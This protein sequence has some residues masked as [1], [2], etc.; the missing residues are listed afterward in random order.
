[1]YKDI[2]S[3]TAQSITVKELEVFFTD[4]DKVVPYAEPDA[5]HQLPANDQQA[6]IDPEP[7]IPNPIIEQE[8]L[9]PRRAAA[10]AG[11]MKRQQADA[12]EEELREWGLF[13]NP[14]ELTESEPIST[15]QALEDPEWKDSIDREMSALIDI[16]AWKEPSEIPSQNIIDSMFVFKLK[17]NGIKKSRLVA[18]GFQQQLEKHLRSSPTLHWTTLMLI[19]TL[20]YTLGFKCAQLDIPNA[21]LNSTLPNEIKPLYL[22]LLYQEN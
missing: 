10:I 17:R 21:Y 1:V 14:D 16:K 22:R 19:I 5:D 15:S 6:E 2:K 9:R 18:R 8:N 11:E 7:V 12:L 20:A 13:A 4:E 3:A